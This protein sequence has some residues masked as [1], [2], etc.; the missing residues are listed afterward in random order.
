[1]H[2]PPFGVPPGLRRDVQRQQA[3]RAHG[4]QLPGRARRPPRRCSVAASA[5]PPG[6]V[7]SSFAGML[8]P[9]LR[10][11]PSRHRRHRGGPRAAGARVGSH[12]A[13]RAGCCRFGALAARR[14][15]ICGPFAHKP[16]EDS[17][18]HPGIPGQGPQP[19]ASTNS[20]TGA[21]G[22]ARA[23][24]PL[25]VAEYSSER[26]RGSAQGTGAGAA[27]RRGPLA[28]SAD[29]QRGEHP[30]RAERR[31]GD[32]GRGRVRE[33]PRARPDRVWAPRRDSPSRS[34][35]RSR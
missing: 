20:A 24:R 9:A 10:S 2:P 31:H 7:R 23:H 11:P 3:L 4:R 22:T 16:E 29:H 15:R 30:A 33:P 6:G 8:A 17:N 21:G 5:Q 19:C 18:L 26:G 32:G 28:A 25:A 12:R 14:P 27:A 13:S 1:M 35:S 34:P